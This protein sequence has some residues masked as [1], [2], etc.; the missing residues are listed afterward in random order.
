MGGGHILQ[1]GKKRSA[2][3]FLIGLSGGKNHLKDLDVD[4]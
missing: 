4:G 3:R 2:S 1:M